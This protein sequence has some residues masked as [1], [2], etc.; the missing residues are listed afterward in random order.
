MFKIVDYKPFTLQ[1]TCDRKIP[2]PQVVFYAFPPPLASVSQEQLLSQ[3]FL[4]GDG[5]Q[6]PVGP[7][8]PFLDQLVAM[9]GTHRPTNLKF[10]KVLTHSGNYEQ[11][12]NLRPQTCCS[13]NNRCSV[14][15]GDGE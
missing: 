14:N 3:L 4:Q 15:A 8:T 1:I 10:I 7:L 6:P 2:L 12:I 5:A 11:W 13:R 9:Q